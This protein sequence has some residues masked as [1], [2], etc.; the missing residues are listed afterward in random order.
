MRIESAL[1]RIY[2]NIDRAAGTENRRWYVRDYE[3]KESIGG[4]QRV[5]AET[6]LRYKEMIKR[7][8]CVYFCWGTSATRLCQ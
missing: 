8:G 7:A 2:N 3:R 1:K 5:V 6:H 4:K